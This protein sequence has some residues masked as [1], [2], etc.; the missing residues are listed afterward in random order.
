VTN[1]VAMAALTDSLQDRGRSSQCQI[2]DSI[3]A[4]Q[5]SHQCGPI[6]PAETGV[7]EDPARREC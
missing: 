7:G 3:L 2:W 6:D 4:M 1:C 5:P